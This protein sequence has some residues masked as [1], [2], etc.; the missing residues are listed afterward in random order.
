VTP[1]LVLG[2]AEQVAAY[3]AH[4]F[5]DFHSIAL[6]SFV[7]GQLEVSLRARHVRF[8]VLAPFVKK[9]RGNIRRVVRRFS[10]G[11][12]SRH[13]QSP[14]HGTIQLSPQCDFLAATCPGYMDRFESFLDQQRYDLVHIHSLTCGALCRIARQKG[15]AVVY[16]HH[17]MLSERHGSRD[18]E[19]LKRELRWVDAVIC[20][21]QAAREDFVKTTGFPADKVSAIP[22]P[23]FL[24]AGRQRGLQGKLR[25]GTASNLEAAKGIDVLLQAWAE[26]RRRG[27]RVP[28]SIAGGQSGLI[29]HWRDLASSLQ[30]GDDVVFLGNLDETE[31][32][33]FY[34]NIELTVVPSLTES[35]SL[36]S[37]EA[38]SRGIPVVASDI[39][40]LRE[41]I[42]DSGMLFP[43]GEAKA[44]AD[45]V[46]RLMAQKALVKDLSDRG[47]AR[48]RS[49]YSPESI[50]EK[51]D[52]LYR[53][54]QSEEA[55]QP[56]I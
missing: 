36:Q 3:L 29:S 18:V 46:E 45:C 34:D 14:F 43:P 1:V 11:V 9:L 8:E 27:I 26:L 55:L 28:L 16:G 22:N 37:I 4:A 30:V 32:Q 23:S 15:C 47:F 33:H 19:F 21:S 42:G 38:L 20:V 51:Y 5:T 50:Y 25:A 52:R 56:Q 48:W 12:L 10:R 24:T 17:N 6:V 49:L 44:L 41:V 53:C 39:A 40:A 35:F 31:M 2:G 7:P 54:C 13:R